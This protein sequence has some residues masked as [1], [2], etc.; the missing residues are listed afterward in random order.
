MSDS[1]RV[2]NDKGIVAFAEFLQLTRDGS[3]QAP[4]FNLL[5]DSEYSN[6]FSGSVQLQAAVFPDAYEF[7]KYLV[8]VL[9]PLNRREIAYNYQLWSWLA[10]YFFDQI[11]PPEAGKRNVLK[12]SAYILEAEYDHR[13][14]YRHLVRTPWLAVADNQENAKVLLH[15]KAG[16]KRSDIFEQLASRQTLFGN[17]T[18]I[19]GAYKLYYDVAAQ[20]PKRGASGKGPGSP[21]RLGVFVRQIE[22]TYDLREC[23]PEQF[24]SLLPAEYDKYRNGGTS[25]KGLKK[26][27]SK[28]LS[29]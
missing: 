10:L 22:L 25:K 7:G 18:V 5:T 20:T 15:T 16:G 14:Y 6:D 24:I 23:T 11:C 3:T 12:D 26:I 28:V 2:L 17:P 13:R 29:T 8:G 21:R 19:A 4:P 1:L 9:G 27:L